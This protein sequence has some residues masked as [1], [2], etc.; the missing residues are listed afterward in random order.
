MKYAGDLLTQGNFE[1]NFATSQRQPLSP[2]GRADLTTSA[3]L[4]QSQL[5]NNP[6]KYARSL[7]AGFHI[8]LPD[9]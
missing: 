8:S 6:G 3:S 7:V 1:R 5:V 9:C 2:C 4:Q